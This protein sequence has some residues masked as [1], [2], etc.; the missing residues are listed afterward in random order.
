MAS[1]AE[2]FR[3]DG[4]VAIIAGVGDTNSR[5]MALALAEAGADLALVA[6]TATAIEPLA[7]EIRAM[8][9]HALAIRAD[10]TDR[11]QVD[12]LAQQVRRELGRIDILFNHAGSGGAA[13]P[14]I[15]YE[16]DE[17][18]A[19]F[20]G[21]LDLVFFATRAVARIMIEQ[22]D[23]GVIVNTSSTASRMTPPMV[24]PYAVAK[25]GVNHLTRCLAAELAPHGIRVNAIL[26]GT[27]EN[28][29]PFLN[30]MSPGF[31]DWW[32]RETPLGRW[33][34]ASE[35]AGAALYLA[36]PASSYVTGS[37]LSVTG[38]IAAAG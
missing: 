16:D 35:S 38:G 13:K 22:G 32:L 12:A 23:G 1:L 21:N 10:L 29:G 18:R 6:R 17:W 4:K 15:D 24:A 14:V 25:A 5:H 37:I 31:G 9:R 36:S 27:F 26:L 34:G 8:G 7:D 30:D 20:A 28:A 19:V 2:A 3:L 33:G 11:P